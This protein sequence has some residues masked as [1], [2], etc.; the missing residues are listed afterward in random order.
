VDH[1]LFSTKPFRL[2][3]FLELVHRERPAEHAAT[4]EMRDE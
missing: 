3:G 2:G 1:P 4:E